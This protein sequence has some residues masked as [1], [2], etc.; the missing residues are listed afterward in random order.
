MPQIFI[1]VNVSFSN[2]IY[3]RKTYQISF[4]KTIFFGLLLRV[5]FFLFE[6]F[7]KF[8]LL[9]FLDI[10][11]FDKHILILQISL[12]Y[13]FLNVALSLI[14]AAQHFH[15]FEFFQ[16]LILLFLRSILYR[17]RLTIFFGRCVDELCNFSSLFGSLLYVIFKLHIQEILTLIEIFFILL[18]LLQLV[19]I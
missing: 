5:L 10:E 15:L 9:F 17:I 13:L 3:I 14:N 6:H 7:V 1:A 18:R 8:I 19:K 4:R 12:L 11:K 2:L 16:F